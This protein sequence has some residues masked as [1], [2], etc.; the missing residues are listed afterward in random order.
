MNQHFTLAHLDPDVLT[1]IQKLEQKLRT[2]ANE[3]IV[4]IAYSEQKSIGDKQ[5]A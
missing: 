2:V 5:Q 1:E 3:N 4:L